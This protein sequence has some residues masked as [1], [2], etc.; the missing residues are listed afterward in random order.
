MR[1]LLVMLA[2]VFLTGIAEAGP[3]SDGSYDHIGTTALSNSRPDS[4]FICHLKAN[5]EIG[6]QNERLCLQCHG[7]IDEQGQKAHK[8][9]AVTSQRY[10]SISCEGCHKVHSAGASKLLVKNEFEL[11]SSCH[12]QTRDFKSH[13]V[14]SLSGEYAGR[15]IRGSDGRELTCASHCHDVHGTDYKYFCRLEP[16]RELCISC[17]K[18]FK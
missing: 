4:C 14:V 18:D 13:P 15:D 17:H 5:A 11:C 8:H 12:T 1:P 10:P 16:G 7:S 9:I 6:S 3:L 2:V